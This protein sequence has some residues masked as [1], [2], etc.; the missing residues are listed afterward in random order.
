[1]LL[2]EV[3]YFLTALPLRALAHIMSPPAQP[4]GRQGPLVLLL[5]VNRSIPTFGRVALLR[6]RSILGAS[7]FKLLVTIGTL[8]SPPCRVAKKRS[9]GFRCYIF[10]PVP[11]VLQGT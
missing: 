9:F 3:N 11:G 8:F 10:L 6:S 5:K 7:S 2:A 1:M 4:R